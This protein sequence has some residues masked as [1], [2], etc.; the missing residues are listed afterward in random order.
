MHTTIISPSKAE[1]QSGIWY[2]LANMPRRWSADEEVFA[3]S[4]VHTEA[5]DGALRSCLAQLWPAPG[6][7][8]KELRGLVQMTWKGETRG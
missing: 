5:R 7:R 1:E 3:S 6:R 8:G 4:R 2:L